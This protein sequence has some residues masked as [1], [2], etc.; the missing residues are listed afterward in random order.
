MSNL[1]IQSSLR[2]S[3]SHRIKR[4]HLHQ[5]QADEWS[6]D[7]HEWLESNRHRQAR[8]PGIAFSPARASRNPA[9]EEMDV[10]GPHAGNAA[11]EKGD[12]MSIS[13]WGALLWGEGGWSTN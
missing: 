9:L 6:R 7:V 8:R 13:E 3:A 11:I 2:W 12:L 4:S 1:D 10:Q 5:P